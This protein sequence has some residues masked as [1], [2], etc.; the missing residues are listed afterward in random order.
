MKVREGIRRWWRCGGGRREAF[1]GE[2]DGAMVGGL[3]GGE[4]GDEAGEKLGL[5]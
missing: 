5:R 2:I 4:E 3:V 1:L